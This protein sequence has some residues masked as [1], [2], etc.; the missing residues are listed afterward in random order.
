MK[1]VPKFQLL[2][3]LWFFIN[4]HFSIYLPR[5]LAWESSF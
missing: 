4:W 5:I 3:T 1:Y 2:L